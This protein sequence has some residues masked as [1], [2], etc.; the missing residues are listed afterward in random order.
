[1]ATSLF[2][3]EFEHIGALAPVADMP[4]AA[5]LLD[6]AAS[7][8]PEEFTNMVEQF[9]LSA[10]CGEDM[11]KRQRTRRALRFHSGPNG[12]IGL[13]GLLPP[14]EGTEL[15]NRLAAIVDAQ[16]R[17][18]HPERARTL[19]A[20]GGDVDAVDNEREAGGIGAQTNIDPFGLG[21]SQP[22]RASPSIKASRRLS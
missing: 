6:N 10:S 7:S 1:M 13:S 19:G 3:E 22:M 15:K 16:W 17:T 2:A 18:E 4:G 12:M 14:I 8:S 21:M 20:Q 11:A 9:R 5:E